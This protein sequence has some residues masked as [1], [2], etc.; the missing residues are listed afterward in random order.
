MKYF[1][2]IYINEYL[3]TKLPGMAVRL[4]ERERPVRLM[5]GKIRADRE[6]NMSRTELADLE[7]PRI[8]GLQESWEWQS[9]CLPKNAMMWYASLKIAPETR[10]ASPCSLL[11]GLI[12][13]AH[14]PEADPRKVLVMGEP[15]WYPPRLMPLRRPA[16]G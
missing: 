12:R 5:L 3:A 14:R 4:P 2:I 6:T 8:K 13:P 9:D 15:L 10:K 16:V 7:T 1:I 11:P